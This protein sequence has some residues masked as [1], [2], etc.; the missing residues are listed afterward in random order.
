MKR[1][2]VWVIE[3][4][5]VFCSLSQQLKTVIQFQIGDEYRNTTGNEFRD[6]QLDHRLTENFVCV[7]YREKKEKVHHIFYQ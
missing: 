6:F 3:E 2:D 7:G 4:H 5:G 1:I